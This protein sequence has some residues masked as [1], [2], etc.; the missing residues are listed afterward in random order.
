MAVGNSRGPESL[1][2]LIGELG[3]NARALT[4]QGS[5]AFREIVIDAVIPYGPGGSI[6]DIGLSTSSEETANHFQGC[7]LVKAI[8]TISRH[9]M[10]D[11]RRRCRHRCSK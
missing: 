7:K 1:K 2:S 10:L 6:V 5:A 9:L 3:R 4:V 11:K 8:N